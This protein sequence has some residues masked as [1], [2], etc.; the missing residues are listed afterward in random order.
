MGLGIIIV[1]ILFS[2]NLLI[3]PALLTFVR[4]FSD[5]LPLFVVLILGLLWIL[6]WL[7]LFS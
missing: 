4:K 5:S 7:H 2:I 3:I 1:P 6:F